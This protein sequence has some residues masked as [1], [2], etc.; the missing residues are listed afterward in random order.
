[1]TGVVPLTLPIPG[2]QNVNASNL[3]GFPS[4]QTAKDHIQS[5]RAKKIT[6]KVTSPTTQDLFF[7]SSLAF[8]ISA[9]GLPDKQF[10]HLAPFPHAPSAD[11]TLDDVDLAPYLKADSFSISTTASGTPPPQDTV[12]E[13]DL[14]LGI[15]ASV[16]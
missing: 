1:V 14:V 13:A 6:I 16:F 10:A 3:Q 7:L 11:L 2:L 15:E 5:A 9:T 8:S 12:V 4:N